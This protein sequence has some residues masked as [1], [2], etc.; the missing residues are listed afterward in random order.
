MIGFWLSVVYRFPNCRCLALRL[1]LCM[2]TTGHLTLR[3]YRGLGVKEVVTPSIS[4]ARYACIV[5]LRYAPLPIFIPMFLYHPTLIVAL[6][7][8]RSHGWARRLFVAPTCRCHAQARHAVSIP[9][10]SRIT[11]P[12]LMLAAPTLPLL[13][14]L[15]H[16]VVLAACVSTRCVC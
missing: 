11:T 1:R 16:R 7:T 9:F 12:V 8:C 4:P 15:Y 3:I 5:E 6:T 10:F 14:L 2:T 13:T